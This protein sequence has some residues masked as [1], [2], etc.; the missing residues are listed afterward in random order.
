MANPPPHIGND[1][2]QIVRLTQS[3]GHNGNG[4]AWPWE[5]PN[6]GRIMSAQRYRLKPR[7]TST[8][9]PV[10]NIP[11]SPYDAIMSTQPAKQWKYL[12]RKPGSD[13]NIISIFYSTSTGYDAM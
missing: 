9:L 2:E 8:A 10:A 7:I 1:W 6:G 4:F 12:A 11:S 5:V 3:G 13:G